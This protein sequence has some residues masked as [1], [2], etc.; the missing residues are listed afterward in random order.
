MFKEI[1]MPSKS[2]KTFKTN[3]KQVDKLLSAY[4]ENKPP[5]RGRKH[6]DHFTR[7]ALMFLCLSWEVYIEEVSVEVV[8]IFTERISDPEQLPDIVK[9]ELSKK[10]KASKHELEPI[11]FAKDWKA[12]YIES[13]IDYVGKLNTPK[14]GNVIEILNKFHGLGG[15]EV[16]NNVPSLQRVNEIV[17]ARGE[18]AH[19]VF[20]EDYLTKETVDD[21]YGVIIEIVREVEVLFWDYIPRITFSKR[22]WQ[23]T[24][25]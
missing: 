3:I 5:T 12:Y 13:T 17:R 2:Y 4:M 6:L 14:N 20:A 1:A 21:Y 18:I 23:N 8:R 9:K 15:D 16:K 11:N 10:V 7:A 25:R 19:N 22:P 24:F